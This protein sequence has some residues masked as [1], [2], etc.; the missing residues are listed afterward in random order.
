M[1]TSKVVDPSSVVLEKKSKKHT[2]K[3]QFNDIEES[4]DSKDIG[5]ELLYYKSNGDTNYQPWKVREEIESG[6]K[7]GIGVSNVFNFQYS[8]VPFPRKP[9][10]ADELKDEAK[11]QMEQE[12][13][14]KGVKKNEIKFKATSLDDVIDDYEDY[15]IN[16][17]TGTLIGGLS[18]N[19]RARFQD[20]LDTV[21]KEKI[22][23]YREKQ[24]KHEE[25]MACLFWYLLSRMSKGSQELVA[26]LAGEDWGIMKD[27][28]DPVELMRSIRDTHHIKT[29]STDPEKRTFARKKW[30]EL[31]MSSNE[32]IYSFRT[33]VQDCIDM[34]DNVG[35]KVSE[36]EQAEQFMDKLH[37]GYEGL[38]TEQVR[39]LQNGLLE[40][41][42]NLKE[43]YML[44]FSYTPKVRPQATTMTVFST[45]V[46]EEGPRVN[47]RKKGDRSRRREKEDKSAKIFEVLGGG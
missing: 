35:I 9:K 12:Q 4:G 40:Y 2:S 15:G 34:L 41:P 29:N 1:E 10:T 42:K 45:G 27:R 46:E 19:D 32:S 21:Y 5:K 31:S 13:K 28:A 20:H 24:K 16:D 25:N 7:Y 36:Q 14:D 44:A 33:K 6:T 22:K 18:D 30:K 43:A 8:N 37:C 26:D 47:P 11:A 38:I 23:Q 39:G 3:N 17:D